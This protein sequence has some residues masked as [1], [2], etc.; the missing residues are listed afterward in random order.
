MKNG[1]KPLES[2][3]QNVAKV[4]S[5]GNIAQV[6]EQAKALHTA[7]EALKQEY[8]SAPEKQAKNY[9]ETRAEYRGLSS[10][11]KEAERLAVEAQMIRTA[12]ALGIKKAVDYISLKARL[13]VER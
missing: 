2:K 13:L 9:F 1:Y 3:P 4:K 12:I 7:I 8:E 5:N 6:E 11:V 10:K